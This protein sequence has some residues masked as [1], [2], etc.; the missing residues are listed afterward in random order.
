MD[1]QTESAP[2]VNPATKPVTTS[3]PPAPP[4]SH[5]RKT[6]KLP[7]SEEL[8]ILAIDDDKGIV[9]ARLKTVLRYGLA[10]AF[11]AEL[12]QARKIHLEE[13]RLTI[14]SSKPSGD[15]LLDD[16]M[17]MI[18]A[19]NKPRKLNRW[20]LA[21]GNKLTIKQVA[22]RLVE[23][24]VLVIEKKQYSWVIPYPPFPQV[25][26]S[27]KYLVKQHL[28]GIVM[29]GEPAN[30]ADIIL[31]SLL[32][33]CR[34]LRLVFTRDERKYADQKVDTLVQGEVFGEALAKVLAKK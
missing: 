11:L 28:R 8:L 34:L 1:T 31:L 14:S 13:D 32:K 9:G 16:I 15:A 4:R 18:T 26:A 12:V 6:L 24:K 33:G 3:K 20:I 23:R 29:A 22:L 7:I 25:E 2:K 30:P 17:A 5:S 27:A 10:G 19:E 21:I